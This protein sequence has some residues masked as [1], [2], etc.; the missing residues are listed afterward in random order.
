MSDDGVFVGTY[1]DTA[2]TEADHDIVKDLHSAGVVGRFTS[3]IG[4]VRINLGED[5]H[6]IPLPEKRL[7]VAMV[8][9]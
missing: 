9:R 2:N 4:S 3:P 6:F 7:K 5:D 8:P 1:P